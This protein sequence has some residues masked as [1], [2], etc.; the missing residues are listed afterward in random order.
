MMRRARHVAP[1]G[2]TINA[3]LKVRDLLGNLDTE[4]YIMQTLKNKE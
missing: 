2:D 3:D 1:T 4:E